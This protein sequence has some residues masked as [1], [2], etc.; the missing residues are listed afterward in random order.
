[1]AKLD[2]RGFWINQRGEAVH[3]ELIRADERLKDELV[4]KLIKRAE[5]KEK[6]LS[7]FKTETNEQIDDFFE[8]LLQNYGV[9]AKKSSKKGNLTLE[10]FSGTKKVQVAVAE[11]LTFDEKLNIAKIKIDEFLTDITKDA[12]PTIR[13]LVNKAFEVDK[14]GNI[15][16]KKIFALRQYEITDKR[17]LEAMTIIDE[18]KRVSHVKPYIRFYARE[19]IEDS[20]E[21]I[22]L[23][24]AS[25][26]DT[27]I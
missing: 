7:L 22:K 4:E 16:S 24:I 26:D 8:L 13:T 1:M 5:E 9:D 17:W 11:T 23:D 27:R 25:I 2:E 20:Y 10:N 21:L 15:D 18:S 14:K 3:K 19:S 12:G 6:E